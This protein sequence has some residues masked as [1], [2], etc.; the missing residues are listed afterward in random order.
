MIH[1]GF[2][3]A[4]L[5]EQGL[6][7]ALL[8]RPALTG[9]IGEHV[10]PDDLF[11]PLSSCVYSAMVDLWA[12]GIV[13]TMETVADEVTARPGIPPQFSGYALVIE[14]NTLVSR[15]DSTHPS[16]YV[17]TILEHSLR[18]RVVVRCRQAQEIA[19]DPSVSAF[20]ALEQA[21]ELFAGI[22]TPTKAKDES[23]PV[24][25]FCLGVDSFDWL[26]PDL[27][28]R[29]ERIIIVAGEAQ[30]KSML[31]RQI[32]VCCAYGVHPFTSRPIDPIRVL[33]LDLENPE[34]LI[35]RKVRPMMHKAQMIRPMAERGNLRILCR[36]GGI[37]VTK[38]TDARWLTGQ[39]SATAPALLVA[40]P[41]YKMFDADDKW[42]QGARSV[43]TILDDL[44]SRIGFSLVLETHAPQAAGG[45]ARN[46]RPIGSS[47]WMR[48]PEFGISFA[49]LDKDPD[50]VQV[51]T[52]KA[53]DERAWPK[54][55]KRGGDW[56]WSAT[57][58]PADPSSYSAG[59][60][61]EE[62]F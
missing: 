30:G 2:E 43:T 20:D 10:Q 57:G 29:M 1:H 21:K 35:R 19:S 48:W 24:E 8:I 38:R 41:L 26:V 16:R 9:E 18:R 17:P 61:Y 6:I 32:A 51:K 52:W 54:F 22:E 36:P 55:L 7:G 50:M 4:P 62:Q 28:E 37:D 59:H 42:E 11:D 12:K 3:S 23:V 58:H 60:M 45:A 25:D 49:P 40:G 14:M 47:L 15:T 13:P 33:L 39:L 27:I 53:R 46:L 56:P 34:S 31:M 5:S 44:R